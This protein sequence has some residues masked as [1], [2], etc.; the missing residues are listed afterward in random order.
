M[1]KTQQIFDK[2]VSLDTVSGEKTTVTTTKVDGQTG[3]CE[4]I[5]KKQTIVEKD[6]TISQV[7]I[8]QT[9]GNG[10]TV[11]T[12][13]NTDIK[14]CDF[15][16]RYV[17]CKPVASSLTQSKT[18]MDQSMFDS[19]GKFTEQNYSKISVVTTDSE[20]K[21]VYR[22]EYTTQMSTL[23]TKSLNTKNDN[24]LIRTT[25]NAV[26]SSQANKN[27]QECNKLGETSMLERDKA[28]TQSQTR[29][30]VQNQNV[31]QN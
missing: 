4:M 25:E 30:H 15:V 3:D 21:E 14:S 26:C 13:V 11:T 7:F 28:K 1:K 22:K 5:S 24:S 20:L 18:S 10:R 9:F 19:E 29:T 16:D 8:A 17:T 23:Y 12:T 6:N 2:V 31:S 27:T